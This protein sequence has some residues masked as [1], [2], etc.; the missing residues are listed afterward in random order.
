MTSGREPQQTEGQS[1]ILLED[2][3]E[4]RVF[5]LRNDP[6]SIILSVTGSAATRR[7]LLPVAEL[8]V[9][10]DSLRNDAALL[11]AESAGRA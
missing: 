11:G 2:L 8:G 4:V 1:E 6:K 3:L 7:Y 5:V 9:L 10:A